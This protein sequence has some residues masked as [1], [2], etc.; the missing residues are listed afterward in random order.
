[1][2][3]IVHGIVVLLILVLLA[4]YAS[5]IPLASMAPI[6]MLVA[7]NM[8][9]R[10]EFAHILKART[11]DSLVLLITFLLTVFTNLTTAVEVGLVLAVLLFIKRMRE[12]LRVAKV[13]P[14]PSLK[15]E[16]VTPHMVTSQHDCPQISIYTI[17]G[18]LFSGMPICSKAR[19]RT[20]CSI[21]QKCCCCEWAKYRFWT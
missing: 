11:S 17:E 19:S 15:H 10:K 8:S 2:S 16:K 4:P 7:W 20:R 9:E 5:H 21:S 6:L 12:S 3:G 18:P 14:D 1:M 13:L